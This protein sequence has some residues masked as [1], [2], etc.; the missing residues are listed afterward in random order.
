VRF[1]LLHDVLLTQASPG[2]LTDRPP[3]DKKQPFEPLDGRTALSR[4]HLPKVPASGG[5]PSLP[6][7]AGAKAARTSDAGH[8]LRIDFD[9]QG[10][11]VGVEITEHLLVTVTEL[12]A[13]L[14]LL[15]VPR[16]EPQ[17]W[18]PLAA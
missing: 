12:N 16:L 3:Y 14:A 4:G 11:P 10:A 1:R 13:V 5:L 15:G 9:A 6:R 2:A 7:A 17:E 8:G 18:A